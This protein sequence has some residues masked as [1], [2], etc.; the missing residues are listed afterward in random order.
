[1]APRKDVHRPAAIEPADYQFVAFDYLPSSPGDIGQAMFLAEE[2]RRKRDHMEKS[3][4]HYSQ[5]EHGGLC[6]ICGSVNAIYSASFYHAKS[7]SYIKAGLDCAQKLECSGIE[8]FRKNVK[9]AKEAAAGKRKAAAILIEKGLGKAWEM[10]EADVAYRKAFAAENKAWH[11]ANPDPEMVS[12]KNGYGMV[13]VGAPKFKECSRD[14]LTAL[15]IVGRLIKWGNISDKAADFLGQLLERIEKAPE[16][17]AAKAAA[18][19][20]EM[21]NAKPVPLSRAGSR[22]RAKCS[23]CVS[24]KASTASSTRCWSRPKTVSSSG[25]R[26]RP[27]SSTRSKR[28]RWSSSPPR[29]SART[30]TNISAFSADPEEPRFSRPWLPEKVCKICIRPLDV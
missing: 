13:A 17:A 6:H 12:D 30:T 20:E 19:A 24:R 25:A 14:E 18:K 8:A 16:V 29:S 22:S 5:H 23:R 26:S 7:N 21:A 2:R 9:K 15:D 10:Y 28:A 11:E 3:G 1:M 4:G 27:R